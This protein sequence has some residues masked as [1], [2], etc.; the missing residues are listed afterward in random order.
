MEKGSHDELMAL[1]DGVYKELVMM[2]SR[3][4]QKMVEVEVEE[5][6]DEEN[7]SDSDEEGPESKTLALSVFI[8]C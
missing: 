4:E 3:K 8:T 2:Q 7:L 5:G 6:T 1:P